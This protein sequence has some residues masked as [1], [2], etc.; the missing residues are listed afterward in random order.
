MP[1]QEEHWKEEARRLQEKL[2]KLGDSDALRVKLEEKYR[3][4]DKLNDLVQG[5]LKEIE[6]LRTA[7]ILDE[8]CFYYILDDLMT[9]MG[10]N[11]RKA[12]EKRVAELKEIINPTKPKKKV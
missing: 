5:K 2:N 6:D 12:A 8:S 1:S 3:E 10:E 7:L 9:S 11:S 4:I